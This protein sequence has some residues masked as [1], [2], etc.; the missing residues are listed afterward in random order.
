VIPH[1]RHPGHGRRRRAAALVVACLAMTATTMAI[2][3]TA[4]AASPRSAASEPP[5]APLYPA[6]YSD[7]AHRLLVTWNAPASSGDSNLTSYLIDVSDASGAQWFV[8]SAT[9]P[10]SATS[11]VVSGLQPGVSYTVTVAAQNSSG[12]GPASVTSNAA[13]VEGQPDE[14]INV[15]LAATSGDGLNV[16]WQTPPGNGAAVTRTVVSLYSASGALVSTTSV[17]APGTSVS[18]PTAIGGWS[19]FVRLRAVNRFGTSAPTID[20]VVVTTSASGTPA[21]AAVTAPPSWTE[22]YYVVWNQDQPADLSALGCTQAKAHTGSPGVFTLLDFGGQYGTKSV[23]LIPAPSGS[24]PLTELT[25]AQVVAD[26]E[27]YASGYRGCA[28]VGAGPLTIGITTNNSLNVSRELGVQWASDVVNPAQAWAA[29]TYPG[30]VVMAASDDMEP[31]FGAAAQ[32][33]AWVKG[34]V[35]ASDGNTYYNSGSADGCGGTTATA[36]CNNGWTVGDEYQ[37][38]AGIDNRLIQMVPQIYTENEVMAQQW[39]GISN[40]GPA[41]GRAPVKFAGELTMSTTCEIPAVGPC[42]GIDNTPAQGWDQL[43]QW[44][45]SSPITAQSSLPWSTDITYAPGPPATSS[46]AATLTPAGTD[47]GSTAPW[48]DANQLD[49]TFD[50]HSE[51]GTHPLTYYP[52]YVTNA[53]DTACRVATPQAVSAS[54][55]QGTSIDLTS[56]TASTVTLLAPKASTGFALGLSDTGTSC[57]YLRGF[58]IHL[59]HVAQVLSAPVTGWDGGAA[60]CGSNA[61]VVTEIAR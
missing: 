44:L 26:S 46:S 30:Q 34:Y 32:A 23:L 54:T 37:V 2:A 5:S 36:V 25:Y 9:A 29:K 4:A 38:A 58:S 35:S 55:D 40:A 43:Y 11:A 39:Q 6:A 16:S 14:P 7:G 57:Q 17:P 22:S 49:V 31:G 20:S 60:V 48:C 53:G 61:A 1:K 47:A 13:Q 59:A 19:Y 42:P 50:G 8:T 41:S 27:A 56:G 15:T 10:G 3:G 45:G 18:L 28:T 24:N 52:F 33:L 51:Y 21:T 12:V